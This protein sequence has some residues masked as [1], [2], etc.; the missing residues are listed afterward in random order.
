M[1][2]IFSRKALIVIVIALIVA[3]AAVISMVGTG[4]PGFV[5]SAVETVLK[6]VKSAS[7]AVAGTCEK[8]YGYMHDYDRLVEENAALRARLA[9]ADREARDYDALE[10]ENIRLRELLG[11]SKKSEDYEYESA[12]I[13]AW[14]ASSRDST[15]TINTGSSNSDVSPGDPV[16]TSSGSVVG[17]VR[18]VSASSSVCVSLI[19]TTFA[20]SVDLDNVTGSCSAVGD[21]AL[22]RQGKLLVEYISDS[23]RVFT[24]DSVITSGK[25]GLFPPDLLI[26]YVDTV[27]ATSDGQNDVA[28]VTPAVSLDDLLYVY[29]ITDFSTT[30]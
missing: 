13:I 6:P 9:G 15:F 28:V 3:L 19:D 26:G 30:E 8:L 12:S 10:E 29:V 20:V 16:I 17:L 7:A 4:K 25:G 14:S 18:T 1:K 11:L 21:Y 5:T 2:K 23:N 27:T 24:G 22:M